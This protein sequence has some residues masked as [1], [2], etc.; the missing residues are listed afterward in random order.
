MHELVELGIG[1]YNII[2]NNTGRL[3]FMSKDRRVTG[4]KK[5]IGDYN[6]GKNGVIFFNLAHRVIYWEEIPEGTTSVDRG[7]SIIIIGYKLGGKTSGDTMD[8][9]KA[10][11]TAHHLARE[12]LGLSTYHYAKDF[13]FRYKD[14]PRVIAYTKFY[15]ILNTNIF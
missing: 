12:E 3:I 8:T 6:R 14:D 13:S 9:I 5:A 15:T 4:V 1:W 2:N 11:A 7:P 10:K